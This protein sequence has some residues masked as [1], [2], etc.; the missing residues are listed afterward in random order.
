MNDE[1]QGDNLK[2]EPSSGE[3][4]SGLWNCSQ[5]ASG[6]ECEG[7]VICLGLSDSEMT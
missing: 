3:P 4:S 1:F 2:Q 6:K 5:G 7:E